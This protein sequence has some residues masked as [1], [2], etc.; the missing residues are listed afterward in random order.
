MRISDVPSENHEYVDFV[1]T[2][3]ARAIKV[4]RG[5]KTSK[6][7]ACHALDIF[8]AAYPFIDTNTPEVIVQ[9]ISEA[10][11]D[12]RG[13]KGWE[14]KARNL[15]GLQLVSYIKETNRSGRGQHRKQVEENGTMKMMGLLIHLL[16]KK[17]G[18][19]SYIQNGKPNRTAIYRDIEILIREEGVSLK[20]IAKATFLE[21]M[22]RAMLAVHDLD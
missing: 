1:R 11:D 19:T 17:T 21:K 9:K 22:S 12:L 14:E 8:L 7:E 20:G 16:I 13:T 18:S 15:G 6:D 10:I 3:I 5:E 4:H 2:H